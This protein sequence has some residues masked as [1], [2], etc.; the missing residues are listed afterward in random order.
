[1]TDHDLLTKLGNDMAWVKGLM[2]AL[3]LPVFAACIKFLL[4][5]TSG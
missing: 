4:S 1:M 2:I 3:N 5:T